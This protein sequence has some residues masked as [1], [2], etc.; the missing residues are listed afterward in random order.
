MLIMRKPY[1][2]RCVH[3]M[4]TYMKCL[5]SYPAKSSK[6]LLRDH[7]YVDSLGFRVWRLGFGV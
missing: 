7:Q 4:A 6:A 5:N 2:L 1:Y 3:V